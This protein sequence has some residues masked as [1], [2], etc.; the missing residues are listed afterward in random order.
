M[1]PDRVSKD[2]ALSFPKH[3]YRQWLDGEFNEPGS[4]RMPREPL[5][6]DQRL[7]RLNGN[8]VRGLLPT[9]KPEHIQSSKRQRSRQT[10]HA[11]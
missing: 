1:Q 11:E 10:A 3:A 4:Y 6:D 9:P 7:W 8:Q 2:A 5:I